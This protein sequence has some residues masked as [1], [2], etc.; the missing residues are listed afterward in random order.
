MGLGLLQIVRR[1]FKGETENVNQQQYPFS[2]CIGPRLS[3]EFAATGF[4][5]AL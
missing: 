5:L 2:N 4:G 1:L 3:T